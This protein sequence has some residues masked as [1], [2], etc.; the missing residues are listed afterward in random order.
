[1][2]R[3]LMTAALVAIVAIGMAGPAGA[4]GSVRDW[5]ANYLAPGQSDEG[6]V[7]ALA[8]LSGCGGYHG[9]SSD[10][11]LLPVLEDAVAR[12]Y[13]AA[14]VQAAFDRYR[15]IPGANNAHGY[16]VLAT[17]LDASR[18]PTVGERANWF[19]VR[20]ESANLRAGPDLSTA[21]IGHLQT[22]QVVERHTIAGDWYEVTS[23]AGASDVT[24]YVHGSLVE[25]Y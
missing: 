25:P 6:R 19:V 17:A 3:A 5:T 2:L 9:K 11:L 24:G 10:L 7:S 23:W 13:D 18:C 21:P 20:V 12:G 14:L 22:G 4:C 15:C 16:E 8:E 1:M